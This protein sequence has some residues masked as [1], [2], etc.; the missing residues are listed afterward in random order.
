MFPEAEKGVERKK[1]GHKG[2]EGMWLHVSVTQVD[3]LEVDEKNKRKK[4]ADK[5]QRIRTSVI[6]CPSAVARAHSGS[7]PSAESESDLP[8][9][10]GSSAI[11]KISTDGTCLFR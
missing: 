3:F 2:R 10:T 6:G 1:A 8:S 9:S 7:T 4:L 11:L 5:Q